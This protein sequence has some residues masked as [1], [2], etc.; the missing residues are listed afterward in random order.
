MPYVLS[1][2]GYPQNYM[3]CDVELQAFAVPTSMIVQCAFELASKVWF[4][5][6]ID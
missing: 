2:A 3:S 4:K 5:A 6:T 1:P